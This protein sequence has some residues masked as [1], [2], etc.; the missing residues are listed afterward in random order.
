MKRITSGYA[1][2]FAI[3]IF[4]VL[5]PA[6][7]DDRHEFNFLENN[8]ISLLN[9]LRQESK[10][11][12]S[13]FID[14]PVRGWVKES[15]IPALIALLDSDEPCMSVVQARSS[16]LPGLS[17]V[18]DEAALLINGFRNGFYPSE[19]NSRKY[20]AAEKDILRSWWHQYLSA[21]PLE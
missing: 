4:I 20:S 12:T 8:A 15:D 2:A 21:K 19:L 14:T 5:L 13:L 6:K 3:V 10:G 17:T 9:T 1:I 7:A 16:Y 18:G 11:K